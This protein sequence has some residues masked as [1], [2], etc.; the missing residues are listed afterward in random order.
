MRHPDV[1]PLP[2]PQEW[3]AGPRLAHLAP[4]GFLLLIALGMLVSG[5]VAQYVSARWGASFLL[6][7]SVVIFVAALLPWLAFLRRRR[8]ESWRI[9]V[10][11][12]DGCGSYGVVIPYSRRATWLS[13]GLLGAAFLAFAVLVLTFPGAVMSEQPYLGRLLVVAGGSLFLLGW[14]LWVAVDI[15]RGRVARGRLVLTPEV[16]VHRGWGSVSTVPWSNVGVVEAGTVKLNP[17]LTLAV[18][19]P[20][21]AQHVSLSRVLK[22][23]EYYLQPDLAMLPRRLMIDPAVLFHALRF[24]HETPQARPEL[25]DGRAVHRI[26]QCDF[27]GY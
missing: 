18:L 4:S 7:L 13:L 19:F 21:A 3:Q 27:G 6:A 8:R 23:H 24:Y 5:V 26:Y 14:L 11:W 22:G 17:H 25:G 16:V 1:E 15:A 12:V 20:G 2:L 10:E 9:S